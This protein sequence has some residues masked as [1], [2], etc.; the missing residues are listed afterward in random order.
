VLRLVVLTAIPV[1]GPVLNLL[2]ALL[3]LGGLTLAAWE[4]WARRAGG[5]A[6]PQPVQAA[7][8][9]QVRPDGILTGPAA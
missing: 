4:R 1:L 7:E 5:T 6:S 8:P 2:A 3:G 9:P